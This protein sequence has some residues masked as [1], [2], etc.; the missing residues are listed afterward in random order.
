MP[1]AAVATLSAIPHRTGHVFLVPAI[2]NKKGE[3]VVKAHPYHN[4]QRQAGGQIKNGWA[5]ACKRAGIAG[6]R[7]HDLR[8]TWASWQYCLHKDLLR[9]RNDGGWQSIDQVEI[10][11][12]LIPE[13]YRTQIESI[14][15]G[16]PATTA[17]KEA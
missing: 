3:T 5:S 17:R 16:V 6:F 2:L 1:P 12:H 4:N 7:P 11:A 15:N 9:L 13:A 8:H 14:L 10:Y